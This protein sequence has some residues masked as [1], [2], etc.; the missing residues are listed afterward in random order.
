MILVKLDKETVRGSEGKKEK[1][2][3]RRR[4]KKREEEKRDWIRIEIK[5][6]LSVS[7][8]NT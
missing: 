2:R 6:T 1:E 8:I 3:K 7:C 5:D 4:E